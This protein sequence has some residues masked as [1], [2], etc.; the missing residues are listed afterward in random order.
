MQNG[1]A[2]MVIRG[3]NMCRIDLRRQLMKA[4]DAK[5]GSTG[6]TGEYRIAGME[7]DETVFI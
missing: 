7:R 4:R 2:F 3:N 6:T 5:M 1:V